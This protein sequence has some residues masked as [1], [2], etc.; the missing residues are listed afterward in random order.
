MDDTLCWTHTSNVECT[1]KSSYKAL[2]QEAPF[3][4]QAPN[5]ACSEPKISTFNQVCK[6]KNLAPRVKTFA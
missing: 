1:T 4:S 6:S 5:N 2:M 3:W